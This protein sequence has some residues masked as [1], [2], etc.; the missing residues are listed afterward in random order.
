[1][2]QRVFRFVV[3][4]IL[5]LNGE[6]FSQMSNG[7]KPVSVPGYSFAGTTYQGNGFK[8]NL[9]RIS[10]TPCKFFDLSARLIDPALYRPLP[11]NFYTHNQ[12]F[13]CKQELNLEKVTAIPLRFR[14]GSLDYVN[15][16]EQKPNTGKVR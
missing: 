9:L 8:K 3:V 16:L 12:S 7:K 15:Y 1:M 13:F 6:I 5:F 14:L 2:S 4:L 11:V 10:V